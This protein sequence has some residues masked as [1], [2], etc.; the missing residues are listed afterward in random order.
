MLLEVD[1]RIQKRQLRTLV[2]DEDGA[3]LDAVLLCDLD[4]LLI[5]QAAEAKS[6]SQI[7]SSCTLGGPGRGDHPHR[8]VARAER[9]V[10]LDL[11]ALAV[12]VVDEVLL[13]E[14]WVQLDLCSQHHQGVPANQRDV[15]RSSSV[16]HDAPGSQQA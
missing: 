13:V 3:S 10:S 15:P 9:R 5:L 11:D 12:A 8:A 4:N 16:Q 14:V 1:A 6:R 7:V 2:R